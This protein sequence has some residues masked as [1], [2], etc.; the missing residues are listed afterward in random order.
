MLN[1][2]IIITFQVQLVQQGT[3]DEEGK[4]HDLFCINDNTD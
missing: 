4:D 1:E 3:W 2:V